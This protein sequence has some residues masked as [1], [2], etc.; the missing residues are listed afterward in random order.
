M[1]KKANY[2]IE[3]TLVT[4]HSVS[5]KDGKEREVYELTALVRL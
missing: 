4:L 2:K 3:A 5:E 1:T